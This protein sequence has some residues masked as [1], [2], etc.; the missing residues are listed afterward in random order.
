VPEFVIRTT[1]LTATIAKR[2]QRYIQPD[3]VTILET[4]RNR[5]GGVVNAND[6]AFNGMLLH[7]S[8]KGTR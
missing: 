3:L 2:L 4:V 6:H 1:A 8:L 7:P 5:L